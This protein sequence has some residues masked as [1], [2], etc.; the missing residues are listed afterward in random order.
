MSKSRWLVPAVAALVL[1][2]A[3]H[4]AIA[5]SDGGP[6]Y[7]MVQFDQAD[8]SDAAAGHVLTALHRQKVEI[9]WRVARLS[10]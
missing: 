2:V 7:L 4:A 9:L 3:P 5:Q 1:L 8:P 10:S 6:Q